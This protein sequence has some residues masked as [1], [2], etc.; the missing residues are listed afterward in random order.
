MLKNKKI[1]LKNIPQL[2]TFSFFAFWLKYI[3]RLRVKGIEKIYIKKPLIIVSNH[4]SKLDPFLILSALGWRNFFRINPLRFPLHKKYSESW[5]PGPLSRIVGCYKIEKKGDLD[6]SLRSTFE[7]INQ[8]YSLIYFPE[9][10]VVKKSEKVEPKKGIGYLCGK[11]NVNI[12]PVNILPGVYD[13]KGAG[14]TWK[15]K[16]V[17]GDIFDSLNLRNKNNLKNLHL[18]VTERINELS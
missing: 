6:E 9:G 12:L 18:A 14:R 13:K 3:L 16:I 11:K 1:R 17:F 7:V 10:Q 4:R 2:L 8:N 5:W 15:S